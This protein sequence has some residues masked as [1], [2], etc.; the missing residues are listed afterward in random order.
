MNDITKQLRLLKNE[1]IIW[2]IYIFIAITAIISN[3]Y[4]K[5]YDLT[6]NKESYKTFKTINICIFTVAFFIYLYFFILNYNNYQNNQKHNINTGQLIAATLFL[7]G[8]LIYLIAE[9]FENN[10]IDIAIN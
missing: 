7:I 2:I 9:I 5:E 4:E 6:Q 8:G 3:K 10:E 1:N